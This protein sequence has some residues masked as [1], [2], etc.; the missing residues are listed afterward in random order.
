MN[1][2]FVI[3]GRLPTP[4]AMALRAEVDNSANSVD[5]SSL[6]KTVRRKVD[7]DLKTRP[8]IKR[9]VERL[10]KLPIERKHKKKKR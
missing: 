7:K 2:E 6:L 4:I 8:S 1:E 3:K 9:E 10:M 5:I